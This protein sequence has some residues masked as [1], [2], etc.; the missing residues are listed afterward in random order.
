MD[1]A[2]ASMSVATPGRTAAGVDCDC[3]F[4]EEE[5]EEEDI[6]NNCVVREG[7]VEVGKGIIGFLDRVITMNHS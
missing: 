5:E 2:V 1:T 4:V 6:L 7:E 3:A